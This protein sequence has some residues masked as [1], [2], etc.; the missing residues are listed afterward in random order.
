MKTIIQRMFMYL[1]VFSIMSVGLLSEAHGKHE[2]IRE[3]HARTAV[4]GRVSSVQVK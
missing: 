4:Q 3:H 2:E 1:L